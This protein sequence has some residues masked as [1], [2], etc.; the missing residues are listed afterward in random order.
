[1]STDSTILKEQA[2][3]LENE[4]KKTLNCYLDVLGWVALLTM[5]GDLAIK[6]KDSKVVGIMMYAVEF[7]T[8]KG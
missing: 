3:A 6:R 1:M 7:L 2:K 8:K 5:L 4:L